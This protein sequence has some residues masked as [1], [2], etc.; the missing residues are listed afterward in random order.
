MQMSS[1]W[2]PMGM[3]GS[4]PLSRVVVCVNLGVRSHLGITGTGKVS[5]SFQ[6]L[7]PHSIIAS[8]SAANFCAWSP[9]ADRHLTASWSERRMQKI[10]VARL[11]MYDW[12]FFTTSSFSFQNL[13]KSFENAEC[14]C[15]ACPFER[16]CSGAD[17]A[18]LVHT[19]R[20]KLLSYE[21]HVYLAP[22]PHHA[23]DSLTSYSY[24]A[25]GFFSA[26]DSSTSSYFCHMPDQ[27]PT[28][29]PPLSSSDRGPDPDSVL[30]D[31]VPHQ[32]HCRGLAA[33]AFLALFRCS[34]PSGE[35]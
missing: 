31:R 20:T 7:V 6:C 1:K 24:C 29:D 8:T 33:A 34:P 2:P 30:P 10:M 19:V 16:S 9:N 4:S 15:L 3:S 21:V 28:G 27:V 25:S 17:Q 35:D 14:R 12:A 11:L 26:G 5:W 32:G 18:S 23:C 13:D 22:C